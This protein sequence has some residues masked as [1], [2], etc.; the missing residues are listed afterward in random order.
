MRARGRW[1]NG[2]GTTLAWAEI[3]LDKSGLAPLDLLA[4]PERDDPG[5][6]ELADRLRRALAASRPAP[7]PPTATVTLVV[8]RDPAWA[9]EVIA[10]PEWMDLVRLVA[11]LIAGSR[12]LEPRDL[13]SPGTQPGAIDLTELQGRADT[14]ELQLRSVRPTLDGPLD[15]ALMNAASFGAFGAIPDDQPSR[16]PAQ[17]Q[18]VAADLDAR[19]ARLDGL[20]AG[21]S[22]STAGV[23]AIR[24]HDLARLKAVF[25][26]SFVALPPL[27]PALAASWPPLWTASLALQGGDPLAAVTWLQRAARVRAGAARLEATLLHAEALSGKSLAAFDVAQLP[28]IAGERWIALPGAVAAS[29]LSLV[30]H[31]PAGTTAGAS[32]AGLLLDEWVEVVPSPQ[33]VT[34]VA[35]QH[36]EPASRAPHVILVAVRPDDFPDWTMESVEG[37][38][39]EALELAKLRAVDPDALGALGHYLPALQFAYNAGSDTVS[40]DFTLAQQPPLSHPPLPVPPIGPIISRDH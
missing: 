16:R 37:C 14:A 2:A 7:V 5:V 6:G 38:I 33:Q 8:E 26:D 13:V 10:L 35:F 20:A 39:L 3:S 1:L 27:A 28:S 30:A 24:D 23:E 11:R 40:T 18:S 12:A 4:L 15:G 17:R 32:V 21:F 25:G 36:R 34:G 31:R 22:R 19:I 29:R 9:P